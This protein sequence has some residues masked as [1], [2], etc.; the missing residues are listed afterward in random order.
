MAD[1]NLDIE[2]E[3]KKVP[4]YTRLRRSLMTLWRHS[5][6]RRILN[7]S[8][9]ELQRKMRVRKVWGYPY[10][11]IIE[12]GNVCNLACPLCPTGLGLKGRERKF[13]S[14]EM[15]KKII[16][17]FARRAYEVILHNWGEPFLNKDIFRM[18]R[19]C[20][21]KNLGT[22][23]SSNLSLNNLDAHAIIDSGLEYLIVSIDGTTQDIY[24]KY[25][26]GGD[27]DMVLRN[28]ANI[29]RVK[30][31]R[32][33]KTLFIEWQ[34]IVMKH[35]MGQISDAKR[36][37]THIGVDLIRFIPP[38]LVFG[39]ENG[40]EMAKQWFPYVPGDIKQ[41]VPERFAQTP[42]SGSCF[43]LYRSVTI[44]PTGAVAPCCAVWE[45]KDDFGNMTETDYMKLWNN[46]LYRN[47]RALFSRKKSP[48]VKT[49]CIYCNL[50]SKP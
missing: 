8:A 30:R 27:L 38:G 37:A 45:E 6:A 9:I 44:N 34:F 35:N 29:V 46:E 43:Y 49:P 3:L 10:V 12:T 20:A 7:L 25:R 23:L 48:S 31:E 47:A 33:S 40:S 13:M 1:I 50:F 11:I 16:D 17:T 21:D 4:Q 24:S 28:L 14:L 18:I 26:V 41:H 32:K 36:M 5:T 39:L 15:F 19:Y 42:M 22:S 2:K